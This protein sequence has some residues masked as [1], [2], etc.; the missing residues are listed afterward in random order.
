MLRDIDDIGDTEVTV[1]EGRAIV[2]ERYQVSSDCLRTH[3]V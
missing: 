2:L 1:A 3:G